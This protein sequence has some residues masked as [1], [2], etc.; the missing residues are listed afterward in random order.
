MESLR[1]LLKSSEC[2]L[3]CKG[4]KASGAKFGRDPAHG[5]QPYSLWMG[6]AWGQEPGSSISSN[7]HG[8]WDVPWGLKRTVK[9]DQSAVVWFPAS[10]QNRLEY[11]AT[12]SSCTDYIS[13]MRHSCPLLYISL[14]R[15]VIFSFAT[16]S[17]N[18]VTKIALQ[19][20][21]TWLGKVYGH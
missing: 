16:C 19:W 14:H 9:V 15:L 2:W 17:L 12:E 8:V 1:N 10:L 21:V 3:P 5:T 6:R 11:L 7:P 18:D 13:Q 4:L 20:P